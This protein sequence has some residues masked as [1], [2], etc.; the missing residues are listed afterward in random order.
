MVS[1]QA[2]NGKSSYFTGTYGK[3]GNIIFKSGIFMGF[4]VADSATYVSS[5][6]QV[7]GMSWFPNEFQ[8]ALIHHRP[9][10]EGQAIDAAECFGN[11]MLSQ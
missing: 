9:A 7:G 8:V 11:G 2:V 10:A 6:P 5:A 1:S 3:Y 4:S